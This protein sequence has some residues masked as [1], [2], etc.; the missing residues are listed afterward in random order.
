[1]PSALR[2]VWTVIGHLRR[3]ISWF[4]IL[5]FIVMM[6]AVLVQVAGRYVFNYSIATATELATFAQI[7]IVLMGSGVAVAKGQ[8]V[9]IDFLPAKLPL[10]AARV[11]MILIAIASVGFLCV[12]AYG[13]VPLMRLG[14]MQTSPAMRLPMW[15]MYVSMPAAAFYMTLEILASLVERWKNPFPD[16]SEAGAVE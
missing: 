8:H 15:V 3:L 6:T 1:M 2:F 12:L 11:A 9:A 13:S 14:M 10:Q 5:L 7:W 16:I 4:V